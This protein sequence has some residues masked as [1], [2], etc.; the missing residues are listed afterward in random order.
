MAL[1]PGTYLGTYEVTALIGAGGMGEVYRGYWDATATQLKR[2][3]LTG[4]APVVIAQAPSN[5]FG[6]SCA[7]D[8]TILFG[9]RE[10]ILRV[11][12]NGGTPELVIPAEEGER[13]DSPHLLP[14]GESVL[15]SVTTATGDARWDEAQIVVQSLR[16]DARTVVLS[17]GS[18]ARYVP[19][20]HLVYALGGV[21]FAV[22]FDVDRLE[23]GGGPV[24]VVQ[25]VRRSGV[26]AAWSDT[27]NYG[28]SDLGTLVYMTGELGLS[29]RTLVWVDRQG[30]EEALAAPPGPYAYPRLSPD[31]TRVAVDLRGDD[32]LAI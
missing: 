11:S 14:D 16:T 6:A 25:G 30:N 26:P 10:G 3:G 32:G 13:M 20:G 5:I 12:A 18:D 22:A 29:Q 9:Q 31:E 21:L 15:F 7:P 2:I 19:T 1:S 28:V 4:G 27:A 8:E 17:G 23:I 24:P